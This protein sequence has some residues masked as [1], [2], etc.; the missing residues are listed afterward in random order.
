M[1]S[2]TEE[3]HLEGRVSFTEAVVQEK[4]PLFY[5]AA[6]VCVIPSY[7]ES[8]G[9]VAL[10]SL[11]CGTPVVATDVGDM[12]NIIRHSEAG[13]VIEVN[14]SSELADKISR[15][16]YHE[17]DNVPNAELRRS[18]AID[19]SW[20]NIADMVLSEYKKVLLNLVLL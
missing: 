7:Y 5:S 2:T 13:H 10:E 18:I 9:M 4:L 8:F 14:S 12:K 15:L 6:D 19:Y 20:S 11:A 1:Q 17:K 16:L 3:L